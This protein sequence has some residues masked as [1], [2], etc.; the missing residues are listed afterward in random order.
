[1]A[2][3]FTNDKVV[4]EMTNDGLQEHNLNTDETV[5]VS[6]R[7]EDQAFAR[8]ASVEDEVKEAAGNRQTFRRAGPE[9]IQ[10]KHSL[11]QRHYHRKFKQELKREKKYD[12][13]KEK[14][15]KKLK[16]KE[17]HMKYDKRKHEYKLHRTE[18]LALT[19]RVQGGGKVFFRRAERRYFEMGDEENESQ[20]LMHEGFRVGRAGAGYTYRKVSHPV[21]KLRNRSYLRTKEKYKDAEK[22]MNL[23][24]RL[25]QRQRFR[26]EMESAW[27]KELKRNADVQS[28]TAREKLQKKIRYKH[29]YKKKYEQTIAQ[30]AKNN[31]TKAVK[32]A[33]EKL[34]KNAR[35][36]VKICGVLLLIGML[37]YLLTSC[38]SMLATLGT[39]AA[40][41]MM[42][43]LYVT[44][45][46][47]I[48]DCDTY[49][50]EVLNIFQN[51]IL[52]IEEKTPGYDEYQYWVNGEQV[53]DA[54]AMIAYVTYGQFELASYLSTMIPEYTLETATPLMDTLFE[55]MFL[56][57]Q[58]EVIERRKRQALDSEGN[59]QYAAD[60]SPVLE[61]YDCH[62]WKISLTTRTIT[63]IM[64]GELT[65]DEYSQYD[66]F[67]MA[68]GNLKFYGSPFAFEWQ[69]YISSQ[70]GYRNHPI[71]GVRKLH[72]G[73][74]IAVPAGTKIYS[75]MD[76]TV[77]TA[78]YSSSAGNWI[79]I[80]DK[81]GYISKYMHCSTLLVG[82]GTQVK[83]GQL[84]A[85][86]GS[87]GNSTGNHLH[88]QLESPDGEYINP[89][90]ICA[91][92]GEEVK[93][94]E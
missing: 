47:A 36:L 41:H 89:I 79:V 66:T 51:D 58:E 45:F 9:D 25:A 2:R 49:F 78:T 69:E 50:S 37:F 76:G 29:A 24:Q 8:G 55:K 94:D 59:P 48:T 7:S 65:E 33:K 6:Q 21:N 82:A 64:E 16:R 77:T 56:L 4:S 83:K 39:D 80:Q 26:L 42:A 27:Q 22:G 70:F 28:M 23:H 13:A 92:Y 20:Q 30:K 15:G 84:I 63:E 73:V 88:L 3:Q 44:G 32:K 67:C 43:G 11:Q 19:R 38:V 61:W 31:F 34:A 85:T 12:R 86:V 90:Y 5:R 68:Q 52:E 53:A 87:T 10:K 74:D 40:A 62:I 54:E 91:E 57:E 17:S 18:D 72:K 81:D 93:A 71:D 75:V 46:D 1:M 35:H 14:Y 60:G